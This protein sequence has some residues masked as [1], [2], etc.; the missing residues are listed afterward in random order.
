MSSYILS[1]EHGGE[2]PKAPPKSQHLKHHCWPHPVGSGLD[3][4]FRAPHSGHRIGQT[5]VL[6]WSTTE[7]LK[8]LGIRA[9]T[10]CTANWLLIPSRRFSQLLQC[11]CHDS[12]T[13][14]ATAGVGTCQRPSDLAR[15]G[16]QRQALGAP[17]AV[18]PSGLQWFARHT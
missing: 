8:G 16:Q 3:F 11:A 6:I 12:F 13:Q 17:G 9:R 10:G 2:I 7:V 4:A 15:V 1:S 14:H 18:G 5:E